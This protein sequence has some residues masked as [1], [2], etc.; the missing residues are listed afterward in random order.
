MRVSDPTRSD[1][2]EMLLDL[3]RQVRYYLRLADRYMLWYRT[4]RF[5]ILF[6]IV[7]EGAVLYFL[8]PAPKQWLWAVA[9]IVPFILGVLTVGDILTDY[10]ARSSSLRAVHLV[11]DDLKAEAEA[12]WRDIEAGRTDDQE[13]EKRYSAIMD[14]WSK[15]IRMATVEVNDSDNLAAAKEANEIVTGRYVR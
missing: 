14:R 5:V 2:W 6:L 8:Y 7:A 11:L 10:G 13:A 9:G 12:L 4:L 15:A 1:I 3:E